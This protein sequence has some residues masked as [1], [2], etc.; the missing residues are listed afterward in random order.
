MTTN[1]A[2]AAAQAANPNPA[3]PKLN[4]Q[5]IPEH[6]A[7]YSD[8]YVPDAAD[9]PEHIAD[10]NDTHGAQSVQNQ[11]DIADEVGSEADQKIVDETKPKA[12]KKKKVEEAPAEPKMIKIKYEGKEEDFNVN[13]HKEVAKW[14]QLGKVSTKRFEEASGVKNEALAV[15]RLMQQKPDLALKQLGWNDAKI[16]EWMTNHLYSRIEYNN[17][18]PREREL[19]QREQQIKDSE[20]RKQVEDQQKKDGT[21]KERWTQTETEITGGLENAWKSVKDV[22][23]NRQTKIRAL[24]YVNQ[25]LERGVPVDYPDVLRT[26]RQELVD[27]QKSVF[28]DLDEESLL[29]LLGDDLVKKI[30]G[31]LVKKV[32]KNPQKIQQNT[33]GKMPPRKNQAPQEMSDKAEFFK[34][35]QNNPSRP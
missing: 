26:V 28:G 31:G 10:L 4:K 9:V 22:P 14:V 1:P 20:L 33:A 17:M 6:L 7:K 30:N 11:E 24:Y 25:A 21:Y 29:S 34:W 13:D 15:A 32:K 35:L 8:N 18:S 2:V 12:A 23:M 16:D 3:A 27:E 19:L 5:G